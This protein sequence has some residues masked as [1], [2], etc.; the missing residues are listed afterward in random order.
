MSD[1]KE[2]VK[3]PKVAKPKV[4]R[5]PGRPRIKP[6]KNVPDRKGIVNA[7]TC[8]TAINELK[9]NQPENIKKI[10]AL[11]KSLNAEKITF[12]FTQDNL[13]LYTKDYKETND[14]EIVL[15]GDKMSS[16]YCK[17]EREIHVLYTNLTDIFQKLDKSYDTITFIIKDEDKEKYMHIVL[18]NDYDMT[19]LFEV[20][21][22]MEYKKDY[23]DFKEIRNSL[24]D[25]SLKFRLK[26]K[27]FKKMIADAKNFG[28]EWTIEQFGNNGTLLF[29]YRSKSGQV[30]CKI[31]P[32]NSES[33]GLISNVKDM[34]MFSVSVYIDNIKPTSTNKLSDN[35][36][37]NIFIEAW[38]DKP[39][40][41]SS[42]L[43][44]GSVKFNILIDIVN[45]N[46]N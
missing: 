13:S 20:D 38:K 36:T 40:W 32:K 18:S 30:R 39:L 44:N 28:N 29:S 11:W 26:G 15:V 27:H 3:T 8:V 34:E 22:V 1:Q 33:V 4:K 43:D 45:Y 5:K 2:S 19:E 25:P 24:P 7:P 12:R 35:M 41:V 23:V 14:V 21:I 17:D 6:L 10:G 9:Y 37:D 46:K 42:S 16:Y 31:V